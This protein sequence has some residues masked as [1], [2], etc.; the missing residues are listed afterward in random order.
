[1]H[2]FMTC[3][4]CV[5]P[6]CVYTNTKQILQGKSEI[7]QL[8]KQTQAGNAIKRTTL[9]AGKKVNRNSTTIYSEP[10]PCIIKNENKHSVNHSLPWSTLKDNCSN[11]R[12]VHNVRLHIPAFRAASE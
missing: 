9:S 8:G 4:H 12:Q 10:H 3:Y 5:L 6:T 7:L 11:K 1:M 2:F